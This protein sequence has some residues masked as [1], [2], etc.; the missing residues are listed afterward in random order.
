MKHRLEVFDL[1]QLAVVRPGVL[2]EPAPFRV[3]QR[4]QLLESL[5]RLQVPD[6]LLQDPD[7]VGRRRG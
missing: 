4:R 2:G 5:R 7:L 3:E 6:D 1:F